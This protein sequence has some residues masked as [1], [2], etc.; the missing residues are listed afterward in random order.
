MPVDF[1]GTALRAM[2]LSAVSLS[3]LVA[4]PAMAQQQGAAGRNLGSV[5]V[6]D[7]A[8]DDNEAE[9]GYKVTRGTSAMRTDTPLIDVPQSVNAIT[10]KQ[11]E[12]ISANNIGDAIR[13]IPGVFS[14]QGESNRETLLFRGNATTGDFF[15]DGMRDDVQTYRDLYNIEQL[16]IFRGSNATIFGRGGIGGVVNRVTKVADWAPHRSFHIEGGS[17]RHVRANFDLGTAITDTV[18]VRL[19][20]V[21]QDSDSYRY[22]DI[23]K[24]WGL[25]PTVAFKLGENTTVTLGYEHFQDDRT[26]DRGVSSYNNRPLDVPRGTFFGNAQQSPT[27][28]N[29]D[30]VTYSLEH[31]FSDA[32]VVRNHTRYADYEKFYQNVYAGTVFDTT[33]TVTAATTNRPG[34]AIGTYAPG[35]VVAIQA[36]NNFTRR[37]NFIS[38]TDLNAEFDTGGIKHTLLVGFEYGRQTTYNQRLEGAFNVPGTAVVTG[39]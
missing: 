19:T 21:R 22:Q 31:R 15:V 16:Q 23:Y 18:A 28:T 8:I 39:F 1:S 20:G 34:L 17:F 38:Q 27:S 6:T 12:D 7:T 37:K 24:R 14:A 5:T 30:A 3:A 2:M 13:Y 10:V 35:T 26:A 33:Q 36:Y 11:I 32:I 9:T 4:V 29:T 25:N